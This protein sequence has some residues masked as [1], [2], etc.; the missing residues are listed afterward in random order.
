MKYLPSE[1]MLA[2]LNLNNSLPICIGK[3]LSCG[4]IFGM[5]VFIFLA[6]DVTESRKIP[7]GFW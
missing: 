5:S 2:P 3:T 4:S 7:G 6:D 1:L